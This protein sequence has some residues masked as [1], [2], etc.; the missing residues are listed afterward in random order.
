[1][2]LVPSDP[3]IDHCLIA[4][5]H[6]LYGGGILCWDGSEATITNN[7]IVD[8]TAYYESGAIDVTESSPTITNNVIA[9]NS[10]F[11]SGGIL[12]LYG[13]PS[14]TNNTIVHNRP[15][16]LHLGP[17]PYVWGDSGPVV[18]NNIIWQNELYVDY[19]VW[20][21]DYVVN[22]NNIQGGFEIED[23]LYGEEA[24]KGE[25][26]IDV[27][28][29]FADPENRDYHLRSEGGRWNPRSHRWVFDDVTS[30]CINGDRINMGAYGGTL[31]A[32]MS[33]LAVG[34]IADFNNDGT[35]DGQDLRMLADIWLTE[36]VQLA[37][38]LNRDGIVSF[39]DLAALAKNWLWEQ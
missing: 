36:D 27:D 8:N 32:S 33:L 1:M 37:E 12:N 3:T 10:A 30:P 21:E 35:V 15:N 38:D 17:T 22:F 2:F 11:V 19:S 13:T 7:T 4:N 5:N 28:P 23:L 14:I 31:Q 25:G 24:Y 20:P 9:H 6:A 18:L 26:N 39:P 34:N 29:C 16:G